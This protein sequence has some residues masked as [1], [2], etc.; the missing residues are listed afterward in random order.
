MIRFDAFWETSKFP[1]S[2]KS[3]HI[4]VDYRWRTWCFSILFTFWCFTIYMPLNIQWKI[5]RCRICLTH[6]KTQ[7]SVLNC[8]CF[9][10][11]RQVRKFSDVAGF[12]SIG[13]GCLT[14]LSDSPSQ[15]QT[16][17]AQIRV[18]LKK[19]K[20]LDYISDERL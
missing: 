19:Q 13:K 12:I 9:V 10:C 15:K 5:R 14:Y 20:K 8:V 16:V 6:T 7:S 3:W 17:H 1:Y 2:T 18:G 11:R 4:K